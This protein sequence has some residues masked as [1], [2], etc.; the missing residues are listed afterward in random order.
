MASSAKMFAQVVIAGSYKGLSKSTRGAAKEMK[1][2]AGKTKATAK[3]MSSAIAGIGFVALTQQLVAATKA[4]DDDRRSMA[5]LNR[6]LDVSWKATDATKQSV[7]DFITSMSLMSGV[8]DDDLRPSYAKLAQQTKSITKA[9]K[10]FQLA[11]DI[12][13]DKGVSLDVATKAVSKALAGSKTAFNKLY[14][15]AKDSADAIEYVTKKSKGAAKIAGD[16]SPFA[17]MNVTFGEL[18]ETIGKQLL[19][20]VDKLAKWMESKQGQQTIKQTTKALVELVKEAVKLGKWAF[21]NKEVILGIAVA[22]KGWQISAGII[23]SWKTL[24]GI[25]KGMKAPTTNGVP[26]APGVG[27]GGPNV[28]MQYKKPIGPKALTTVG[29]AS[30]GAA[31]GATAVAVY[32]STMTSLYNSDKKKFA[33][34]VR[35]QIRNAV[36]D[37]GKTYSAT[38]LLTATG[39]GVG[40]GSISAGGSNMSNV[41]I[42]ISGVASGNDVLNSLKKVANTRGVPLRQLLG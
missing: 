9:N 10:M 21:D 39:T 6:T 2:L 28:P 20:Y 41:T 14:P 7:D 15:A 13:A 32:G 34:E 26:S 5:L 17:K 12:S 33:S 40:K 29:L 36:T 3:I 19:P 23:T 24:A 11:M 31:A 1:T 35:R 4:A 42:N 37:Y 38:E 16:N 8:A 25:W 22:L 27:K 30:V 18:Q